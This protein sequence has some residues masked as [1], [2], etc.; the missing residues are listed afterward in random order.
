MCVSQLKYSAGCVTAP[1]LAAWE[2]AVSVNGR[3]LDMEV[4]KSPYMF[5][6]FAMN[7]KP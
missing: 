4:N 1:D 3:F 5:K 7:S 2:G 6:A